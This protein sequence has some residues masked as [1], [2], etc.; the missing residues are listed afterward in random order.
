MSQTKNDNIFVRAPK[1]VDGRTTLNTGALYATVADFLADGS[2]TPYRFISMTVPFV[3]G[4]DQVEYWFVGGIENSD[5]QLKSV[6]GS[7]FELLS[8]K[9]TN[10]TSPNNTKYPTTLA[11]STAIGTGSTIGADTT[12]NSAT[13][14]AMKVAGSSSTILATN[15]GSSAVRLNATDSKVVDI[16][17]NAETVTNGVYTTGSYA[18]PSWITSLAYSKLTG[19]PNLSVYELLANKQNSLATDGTGIKY[20]TVD[21][22]NKAIGENEYLVAYVDANGN[23]ITAEI[24]RIN[25]AYLT[26]DAA[27]EAI[28]EG[29]GIIKI[30]LG[31]FNSPSSDK[32]KPNTYFVGSG[33][34][35]TNSTIT[36]SNFGIQPII[37][38]P[39]KLVGGTVLKGKF[40]GSLKNNI[41][42][43]NLG[44]DVGLE[45]CNTYNGGDAEEGLFFAQFFDLSGGLPSQ[46]GLHELQSNS[47]PTLNI[48]VDKVT[49]LCKDATSLVHA[50]L[51]ENTK[52]A[53]ISNISTYFGIH[54]LVI[55]SLGANVCNFD[56][57]GHSENALIIKSNDYAYG[58]SNNISNIYISSIEG[59]DSG[60]IRLVGENGIRLSFLNLSNV[61]IEYTKYG[62]TNEGDVEGVNINNI[63]IFK[64]QGRGINLNP[65]F[66][67]S[68]ISNVDQRSGTDGIYIDQSSSV[69]TVLTL[70]N[71]KSSSNSG[72]GF[73]L[74]ASNNSNIY[75]NNLSSFSNITKTAV[76]NGNVFG[77]S[78][79]ELDGSGIDGSLKYPLSSG[80]DF[81]STISQTGQISKSNLRLDDI[82]EGGENLTSVTNRGS[83]SL[84]NISISPNLFASP[85]GVG[86]GLGT[87]FG[88]SYI[89]STN[90][91]D[92]ATPMYY[93]AAI[94][95]FDSDVNISGKAI[96]ST[97]PTNPTDVVR[98]TDLSGYEL[99][100]NKST[101][102]SL[103]T[104]NT[105]Y[106]TQN[107]VKTYVDGLVSGKANLAGGN[108]FSGG[109]V[110]TNGTTTAILATGEISMSTTAN[111]SAFGLTLGGGLLLN[112]SGTSG[113][114]G[115]IASDNLTAQRTY[116]MADVTGVM[117][118]LSIDT[119]P[120]TSSSTG[121]TGT[122]I[123]S[124]LFRY[125][126][127]ATDTWVRSAVSTF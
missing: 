104:S 73:Y 9:S 68:I 116:Q 28:G 27:L 106:P 64:T 50:V 66:I 57:H 77:T 90:A 26:I 54:G 19:A 2:V 105:L 97:A 117:M 52:N 62:I 100:S 31:Y 95:D 58:Q 25:K 55:K 13:T 1:P 51:I 125:E 44:I 78:L 119:P 102:T 47:P 59:F 36:Y 96:V 18:N 61:N 48:S 113:A 110:F 98:L 37:S 45:W 121:K 49:V 84:K 65:L 7:G 38:N 103:G 87:A 15:L 86:L 42:V 127:I 11:V 80:S 72:I 3:I 40:D 4:G 88:N 46:D 81:I 69:E 16:T 75:T 22:V 41:G 94:H 74:S 32:I 91:S 115:I 79:Y 108:S 92:I 35:N 21:A 20:P 123:I 12:G 101:S 30:G 34:P 109:Q 93:L 5:F 17:G 56:G 6:D 89:I 70:S 24:G 60:G 83:E 39:T 8:N 10:L 82:N 114:N 120:L 126:C 67:N 122:V 63:N 43:F 111:S 23:D 29:G 124:G 53:Q 85:F 118:I 99:L 14:T 71:V 76:L 107:A 112:T 33:K